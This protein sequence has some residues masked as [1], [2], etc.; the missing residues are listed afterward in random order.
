[1]RPS[2]ELR[3]LFLTTPASLVVELKQ[4]ATFPRRHSP[5]ISRRPAYF[6]VPRRL[7]LTLACCWSL[8][9]AE[10]TG[11]GV[12]VNPY[13][14]V[15]AA[16][17][18]LAPEDITA[19]R[20]GIRPS[21]AAMPA[22]DKISRALSAGRQ[23]ADVDWGDSADDRKSLR[24]DLKAYRIAPLILG[25]ASL[26]R[27]QDAS[28]IGHTVLDVAALGRHVGRDGA[29]IHWMNE[30]AIEQ[31]TADWLAARLPSL[32]PA[33]AARLIDDLASLPPGGDLA[34]ALAAEKAY[35][36]DPVLSDLRLLLADNE[37]S[38]VLPQLRISGFVSENS[39]ASVGIELADGTTFWLKPGQT[40]RGV[41]LLGANLKTDDAML[42]FEGRL[43]RLRLKSRR[44]AELTGETLA[45]RWKLLPKN[46]ALR[47]MTGDSMPP[48]QSL[49]GTVGLLSMMNDFY[50]DVA[51][52]PGRF[53]DPKNREAR[54]AQIPVELREM[55]PVFVFDAVQSADRANVT[56]AQLS[57]ALSA[58]AAGDAPPESVADP[59]SGR[60]MKII[61]TQTGY[62]LESDS[63]FNGSPVRLTVG[64][65]SLTP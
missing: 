65:P 59:V 47:A 48:A 40:R 46:S 23:A 21:S 24:S 58:R 7:L 4:P 61:P 56:R 49:A 51:S 12:P 28:V 26:A 11:P 60:P 29:M 62:V 8:T 31:K 22:L 44:L 20:Q 43:L 39:S 5:L 42:L 25:Y 3:A 14:N 45:R 13:A 32:A 1:M 55:A 41:S 9:S 34:T 54:I 27:P 18:S 57:A 17:M 33:E 63:L 10:Q 50:N 19:L 38:S 52:D 16:Y 36:L 15:N 2:G 64:N 53:R 6:A 37:D 35:Y 30:M